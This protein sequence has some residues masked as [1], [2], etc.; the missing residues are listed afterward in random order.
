M[1]KKIKL[2]ENEKKVI[3]AMNSV[4][5]FEK[6]SKKTNIPLDRLNSILDKLMEKGLV[7]EVKKY[8]K[9]NEKK[10]ENRKN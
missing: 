9:N 4:L 2:S 6:I 10:M 5:S 1:Q 3:R 7:S 8:L